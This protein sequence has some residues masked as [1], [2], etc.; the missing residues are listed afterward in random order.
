MLITI[1]RHGQSEGNILGIWAGWTDHP[2]T[3]RGLSQ[4]KGAGQALKNDPFDRM[5]VSDLKRA[6]QTGREI[7]LA[8]HDADIPALPENEGMIVNDPPFIVTSS[9]R[10]MHFGKLEGKP[11]QD[12]PH[13]NSEHGWHSDR[14][15]AYEGG[16]SF[17]DLRK[18]A[19]QFLETQI[20]PLQ[21]RHIIIVS[22]GLFI[23][24]FISAMMELKT[25]GK[26]SYTDIAH[27]N[28]GFSRFNLGKTSDGYQVDTLL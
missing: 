25:S 24:E 7:Y 3:I 9:I 23:S 27:D 15:Y 5:F 20:L 21:D 8:Q 14:N 18:R 16:E 22:H 10:E 2:L 11:W 1:V 19:R 12:H 17:N 28:T 4:A 26:G 13:F 6:Y